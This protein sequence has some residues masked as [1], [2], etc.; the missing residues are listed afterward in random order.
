MSRR[1][2]AEEIVKV[3]REN[4]DITKNK[5]IQEVSKRQRVGS[6]T[7]RDLLSQLY[8]L[9]VVGYKVIQR[10]QVHYVNEEKMGELRKIGK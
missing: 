9:G 10:A 7:I 8:I 2:I 3:I 1:K 5:L 6:S 4:K